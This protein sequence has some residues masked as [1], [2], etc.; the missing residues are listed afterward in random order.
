MTY[1]DRLLKIHSIVIVGTASAVIVICLLVLVNERWIFGIFLIGVALFEMFQTF[2][3]GTFY[4]IACDEFTAELYAIE[5]NGL[6]P[7]HR[8][9]LRTVLQL[10]QSPKLTTLGGLFPNNLNTFLKVSHS[11]QVT[12][13]GQ[14]SAVDL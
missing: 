11:Q 9:M 8:T 12:N 2:V 4:E 3:I 7:K 1:M 10:S 5:W 6:S 13:E 14:C